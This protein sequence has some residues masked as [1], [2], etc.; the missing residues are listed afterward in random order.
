MNIVAMSDTSIAIKIAGE[1]TQHVARTSND[2][3]WVKQLADSGRLFGSDP[4]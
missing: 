1:D 3:T 4:R 2:E